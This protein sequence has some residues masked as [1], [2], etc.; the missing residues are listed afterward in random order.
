[1]EGT[2]TAI[3]QEVIQKMCDEY[4]KYPEQYKGEDEDKLYEEKCDNCPLNLL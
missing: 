3:L 1:M 4:C 2:V